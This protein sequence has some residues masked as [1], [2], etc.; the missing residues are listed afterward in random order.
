MHDA[1]AFRVRM[2][3]LSDGEYRYHLPAK[4]NFVTPQS[5][6]WALL[7]LWIDQVQQ[8]ESLDRMSAIHL[9]FEQPQEFARMLR[10]LDWRVYHYCV[11]LLDQDPRQFDPGH[12]IEWG[13]IVAPYCGQFVFWQLSQS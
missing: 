3:R 4:Y 2:S 10:Q 11:P 5:A 1:H 7:H 13:Y 6:P 12:I 9:P 8:H